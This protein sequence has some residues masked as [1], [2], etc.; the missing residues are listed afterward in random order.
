MMQQEIAEIIQRELSD[1]RLPTITS[2]TRVK[3]SS[4]LSTADVFVSMM[5]TPGQQAAGLNALRHSAGLIRTILTKN[6]S[7]RQAPF[8]KFHI[9]EALQKELALMDLLRKVEEEQKQKTGDTPQ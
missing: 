1:P 2:V 5:G 9:D 6:M 4:D 7:L 8:L 3:V